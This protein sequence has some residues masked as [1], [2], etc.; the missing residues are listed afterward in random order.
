MKTIRDDAEETSRSPDQTQRQHSGPSRILINKDLLPSRGRYYSSDLY[1]RKLSA[2]EMKNLSKVRKDTVNSVFNQTIGAAVSGL[3]LEDIEMNDKLWLIYY[4]RSITYDDFPMK[5]SAK[6]PHCEAIKSYDFRLADL[7]VTYADKE[8]PEEIELTNGDK[9]TLQFPTIGTEIEISRM[10]SNPAFIET[11]DEEVM[12]IASHIST[13][14]GQKVDIYEAYVYFVRGRGSARDFARLTSQLRKYA[15]GARPVAKFTCS[16][17]ETV[18]VS[19]PM[20]RDFFLPE[21]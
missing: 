4:L 9:V 21:L 17:G 16:C 12:T 18:Y 2:I 15:F 19:V 6:C 14:N 20:T 7:D 11:I 10:K 3:E 5:I 8:L 1:A 13:I